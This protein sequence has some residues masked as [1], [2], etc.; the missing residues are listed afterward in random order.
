M[1]EAESGESMRWSQVSTWLVTRGEGSEKHQGTKASHCGSHKGFHQVTPE[2]L[3]ESEQKATGS[4]SVSQGTRMA[5]KLR[6]TRKGERS[7]T[8]RVMRSLV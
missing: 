7:K 8:E 4:D 3:R 2:V 5:A 1:F 6:I